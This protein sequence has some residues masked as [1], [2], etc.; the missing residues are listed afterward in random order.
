MQFSCRILIKAVLML[1]HVCMNCAMVVIPDRKQDL[2]SRSQIL[3][4]QGAGQGMK[5]AST[6]C[7]LSIHRNLQ[8]DCW[9]MKCHV[10]MTL[11]ISHL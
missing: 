10:G 8:H 2:H 4:L 6:H 1:D 3:L 11:N 9:H 5:E 7:S